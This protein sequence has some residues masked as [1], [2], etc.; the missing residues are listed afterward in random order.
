MTVQFIPPGYHTITPYLIVSGLPGVISFLETVFEAKTTV[1]PMLRPDGTIMHT[2]L[3][4]G[5]SRIMMAE[6]TEQ[7]KPMPS[8][9]FLYLPDCDAS[10]KRA[11]SAGATSLMEPADQFYGDRMGG[12]LDP[13]GNQWWVATHVEDVTPV[14]MERRKAEYL[15]SQTVPV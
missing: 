4:V 14:E 11:L 13:S 9:I 2:E 8:S 12:V 7:W 6:A 5:D 10:Y 3:Q 15:A 1:A